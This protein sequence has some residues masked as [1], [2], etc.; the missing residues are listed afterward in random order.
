M[1]TTLWE[2]AGM[3]LLAKAVHTGMHS[4]MGKQLVEMTDGIESFIVDLEELKENATEISDDLVLRE[5]E[6]TCS[7]QTHGGDQNATLQLLDTIMVQ[8]MHLTAHG[9]VPISL[10]TQHDVNTVKSERTDLTKAVGYWQRATAFLDHE[11]PEDGEEEPKLVIRVVL[12]GVLF[13]SR[14]KE[15]DEER[16]NEFELK[17]HYQ[18]H[19]RFNNDVLEGRGGDLG[20][21]FDIVDTEAEPEFEEVS[22]EEASTLTPH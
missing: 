5:F 3:T 17:S 20:M 14:F 4:L 6:H 7:L 16:L 1:Q 22:D 15:E 18:I 10:I 2:K 9:S 21:D 13:A 11:A 19:P 12:N 8:C